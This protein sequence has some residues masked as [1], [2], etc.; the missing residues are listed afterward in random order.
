MAEF[1]GVKSTKTNMSYDGRL[2][3]SI[4][5]RCTRVSRSS[6]SHLSSAVLELIHRKKEIQT[7]LKQVLILKPS[8]NMEP[9]SSD[10]C[11]TWNEASYAFLGVKNLDEYDNVP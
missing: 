6:M 10:I 11:N 1:M 8:R 2:K 4:L 3:R 5:L 9:K 7:K